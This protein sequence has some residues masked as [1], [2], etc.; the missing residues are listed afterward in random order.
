MECQWIMA[1]RVLLPGRVTLGTSVGGLALAVRSINLNI[2]TSGLQ[3][4]SFR[5]ASPGMFQHNHVSYISCRTTFCC[6][7][8]TRY[9]HPCT[10]AQLGAA[11]LL[12][13]LQ[14]HCF[15]SLSEVDLAE[16]SRILT[17]RCENCAGGSGSTINVSTLPQHFSGGAESDGSGRRVSRQQRGADRIPEGSPYMEGSAPP[18]Q[19]QQVHLKSASH[20]ESS[21]FISDCQHSASCS[22]C[23][24][25]WLGDLT[26]TGASYRKELVLFLLKL[27]C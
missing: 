4:T 7:D 17:G 8:T 2:P 9:L 27:P 20:F 3:V 26:R 10:K 18:Q 15:S 23:K 12:F 22:P 16:A 21:F 6:T 5:A 14:Q 24:E 25:D 19:E 13:W 1:T 11:R